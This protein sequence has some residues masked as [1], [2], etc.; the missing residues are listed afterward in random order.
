MA[1]I[2]HFVGRDQLMVREDEAEVQ[3]AFADNGGD[4]VALTHH[5]TGNP[6][7][8][9]LAQV[10]YWQ[11]RGNRNRLFLGRLPVRP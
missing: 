7:F 9:N 4:P 10:T 3:A 1:T 6:V 11:S 5:R 2:I 8:V